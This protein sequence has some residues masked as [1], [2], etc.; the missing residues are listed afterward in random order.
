MAPSSLSR[1]S[2]SRR[3]HIKPLAQGDYQP[4]KSG[5]GGGAGGVGVVRAN[6]RDSPESPTAPALERGGCNFSAEGWKKEAE[7]VRFSEGFHS[8]TAVLGV[9]ASCMISD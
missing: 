2:F 5:G 1:V 8:L 6:F 7:R 4:G 3:S 9:R